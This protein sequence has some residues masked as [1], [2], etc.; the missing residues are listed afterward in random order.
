M[1]TAQNHCHPFLG[2]REKEQRKGLSSLRKESRTR[3][4]FRPLRRECVCPRKVLLGAA[5]KKKLAGGHSPQQRKLPAPL[6]LI[7]FCFV[8]K[9]NTGEV[10]SFPL[11]LV[12]FFQHPLLAEPGMNQPGQ[13]KCSA[14][15]PVQGGRTGQRRIGSELEAEMSRSCLVITCF[16]TCLP[17]CSMSSVEAET[18]LCLSL[19]YTKRGLILCSC[20]MLLN[21]YCWN[22]GKPL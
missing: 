9:P 1:V 6:A 7:Y 20:S 8:E 10:P 3:P 12:F 11:S 19:H 16:D 18:V 13:E 5:V 17:H 4:R 22:E 15:S 2:L 21:Q 14:Q